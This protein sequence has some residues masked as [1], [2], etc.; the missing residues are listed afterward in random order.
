[1]LLKFEMHN[2]ILEKYQGIASKKKKKKRVTHLYTEVLQVAF[3]APKHRLILVGSYFFR[4][5]CA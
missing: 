2:K 4:P 3:A 5:Y 1:M